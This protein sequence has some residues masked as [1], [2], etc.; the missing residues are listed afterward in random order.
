MCNNV[1][2]GFSIDKNKCEL[3]LG[4]EFENADPIDLDVFYIVFKCFTQQKYVLLE[5]T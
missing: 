3:T 1:N 5:I 2:D 4:P